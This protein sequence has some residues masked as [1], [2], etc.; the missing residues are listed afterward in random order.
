MVMPTVCNGPRAGL[1]YWSIQHARGAHSGGYKCGFSG[2]SDEEVDII[3]RSSWRSYVVR[4]ECD[5]VA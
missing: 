2:M 5:L 3:W 1:R 4:D